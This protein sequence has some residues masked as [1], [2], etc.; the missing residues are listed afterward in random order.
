MG[1]WKERSQHTAGWLHDQGVKVES[2]AG[3]VGYRSRDEDSNSDS[4]GDT[5][6][7]LNHQTL[8]VNLFPPGSIVSDADDP[9]V[10]SHLSTILPPQDLKIAQ[11]SREW[12]ADQNR[13]GRFYFGKCGVE[14]RMHLQTIEKF[15]DGPINQIIPTEIR[16]LASVCSAT[17][18]VDPMDWDRKMVKT[19]R[20]VAPMCCLKEFLMS[21]SP[22]VKRR[23]E[24]GGEAWMSF[25]DVLFFYE[26]LKKEK[27]SA[28]TLADVQRDGPAIDKSGGSTKTA[29]L[30]K[31]L[32]YKPGYES[33]ATYQ[34]TS[35]CCDGC[36]TFFESGL[37]VS[38]TSCKSEFCMSCS[39]ES[40]EHGNV[41]LREAGLDVLMS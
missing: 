30:G 31:I 9:T 1:H 39:R 7:P 40:G 18:L 21:I 17:R 25:A 29:P 15:W 38:C 23:R 33:S 11:A 24:H 13:K 26:G 28:R 19:L 32:P 35:F 16:P 14:H 41:H 27:W 6:R 8:Q 2:G 12:Q 3:T 22:M 5:V 10:A 36:T 4:S 37:R 34:D 20:K